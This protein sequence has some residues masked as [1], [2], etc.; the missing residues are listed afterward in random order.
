MLFEMSS[1]AKVEAIQSL[2]PLGL[3]HVEEELQREVASLAGTRHSRTE[4][5]PGHVRW[6]RQPVSTY[7]G[8]QKVPTTVPRMRDHRANTEIP[9]A[10]YR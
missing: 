2:I 4:G 3:M 10:L 9:L 1:D 5:R 8:H 6:G 7:L